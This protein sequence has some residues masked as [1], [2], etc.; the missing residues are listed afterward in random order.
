[1][2]VYA[3]VDEFCQGELKTKVEFEIEMLKEQ[4]EK[5]NARL[6]RIEASI[7]PSVANETS[8]LLRDCALEKEINVVKELE[9]KAVFEYKKQMESE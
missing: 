4:V 7:S 2:D 6:A 5:L 9:E 3:N 1:M 8:G